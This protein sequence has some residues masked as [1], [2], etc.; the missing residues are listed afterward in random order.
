MMNNIA[1]DFENLLLK[2]KQYAKT[3]IELLQLQLVDKLSELFGILAASICI[4][5]FAFLCG[6]FLNIGL[7][8]YLGE[9]LGHLYFGFLVVAGIYLLLAVICYVFRKKLIQ[10]PLVD[11]FISKLLISKSLK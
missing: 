10:E 4:G 6:L 1:N 7:A 9:V 2:T 8:L 3:S 5:I 11:L